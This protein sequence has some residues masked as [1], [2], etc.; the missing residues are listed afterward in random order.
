MAT[1]LPLPTKILI[2]KDKNVTFNTISANMGDSYTQS[3][4]RGLNPKIDTW[5]ISWG[6][7][8]EA[9]KQTVESVLDT[10]GEWGLL[11]W[12]PCGETVVKYFR[13]K[14]GTGYKVTQGNTNGVF[15]IST[16]LIEQFDVNP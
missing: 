10:V 3:A 15:T 4:P 2:S 8:S 7:S 6:L 5:N 1:P 9:E 16:T 11:S 14:P 13:I 12:T